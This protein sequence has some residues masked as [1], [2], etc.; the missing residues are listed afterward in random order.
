MINFASIGRVAVN[1]VSL[2]IGLSALTMTTTFAASTA[3]AAQTREIA[4]KRIAI[5]RRQAALAEDMAKNLC[6][7]RA[8]VVSAANPADLYVTW[9]VFNWYHIGFL[10]GNEQL[11][12]LPERN[13]DVVLLWQ[14]VDKNWQGM[15]P[16]ISRSIDGSSLSAQDFLRVMALVD[17]T[18]ER[19][20]QLSAKLQTVYADDLAEGNAFAAFHIGL[21]KR[22]E[23]LGE[24]L[25]K[26]ICLSTLSD[27]TGPRDSSIGETFGFFE[28]SLSGFTD[29]LP[30]L[31]VPAAPTPEI[32]Q[33][34][35]TSQSAWNEVKAL[36]E[37][38]AT[39]R[40][41]SSEEFKQFSVGMDEALFNLS[42]SVD[43]LIKHYAEQ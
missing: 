17:R 31:N 43:L 5:A 26:Q 34:L 13:L 18:V 7:L 20:N 36:A 32:R 11:Q 22:A 30:M 4:G 12:L 8:N 39:G 10:N 42:I 24:R 28:T 23:A 29:G 25:S 14:S 21:F 19:T 3:E 35:E 9:N 6:Y 27:G 40:S 15:E 38:S 33:R 37:L 41:L 2:A 1:C 16:Y